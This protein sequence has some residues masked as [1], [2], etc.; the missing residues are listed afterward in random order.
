MNA[1]KQVE[2]FNTYLTED[3][4]DAVSAIK[5]HRDRGEP[6]INLHGPKD[7]GKT[8]LCWALQADGWDYHQALPDRVSNPAVT[9]DHGKYNRMATRRLRNN[10][11]MNGVACVVYV[12]RKAAEE[13]YPRVELAPA[14]AHYQAVARNWRELGLKPEEAPSPPHE[15]AGD[16]DR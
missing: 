15:N 8:F 1:L 4:Q 10:V 6:Y 7:A 11:E 2:D 13:I 12:T 9:Y 3:Q 16:T 14:T 5:S